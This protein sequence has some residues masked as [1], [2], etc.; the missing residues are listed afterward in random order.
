MTEAAERILNVFIDLLRGGFERATIE[1]VATRVGCAKGLVLY[2]FKTKERLLGAAAQQLANRLSE[3]R[4]E[5][6]RRGGVSALD[7]LWESIITDVGSGEFAARTALSLRGFH[8]PLP[9]GLRADLAAN[10]GVDGSVLHDEKAIEAVLDGLSFQVLL[11]M[12]VADVRER[13]HRL[14]LGLI[15]T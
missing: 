12:P 6:C 14:W 15:G 4:L 3:R 1:E 10:L 8:V 5:A 2:H 9:T 11:G 7:G 13:Y